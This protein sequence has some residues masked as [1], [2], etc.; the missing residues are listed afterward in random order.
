MNKKQLVLVLLLSVS[1]S[2]GQALEW[3]E[4][5]DNYNLPQSVKVFEAER[6]QPALKI[7]YIDVDLNDEN[8]VVRPYLSS[9][10][11]TV[12]SLADKFGA[13]AAI[14]GGYFGGGISYS[15]VIYPD[16]VKARNVSA[17]TRNG[18]SYPVIRSLFSLSDSF[19]PSVDWI[20]HFS[21]GKDGIYSFE[22][23]LAYTYNDTQPLPAPDQSDGTQMDSLL[24]GIGGGPTLVKN[25]EKHVTYNEEIFWG[26]GVGLDNNDPRTAVGYT[27]DNHIILI[28]ADGRQSSSEGV[29]LNELAEIM[30]DLG[31]VEAMNLDGGGSSQMAV[32]G[33]FINSPSEN[34]AVPGILA[35][36]HR[37]SL[38]SSDSLG[39]DQIID[40]ED[41]QCDTIGNWFETANPGYWGATPSLLS[42]KGSGQDIVTYDLNLSEKKTYEI[43]G[44]WVA[45][46]NRCKDTPYVIVWERSRDTVLVD[47][48]KNNATWNYLGEYNFSPGRDSIIISDAATSGNYVVADAIALKTAETSLSPERSIPDQI[49][50]TMVKNFPNPFNNQTK[51]QFKINKSTRVNLKIYNMAGQLIESIFTN[52]TFHPGIHRLD[53]NSTGLASGIYFFELSTQKSAVH[54]KMLLIK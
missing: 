16:K 26:S 48:T 53:F 21:G 52:R 14:N 33:E 27:A 47:Q 39:Y 7:Y 19:L 17:L 9:S 6:N 20:Y 46:N 24:T 41:E 23:P 38:Y 22:A 2:L 13:Y 37:D 31:C 25:S 29:G 45:A 12:K 42:Q 5:S 50:F 49:K 36:T 54:Q 4:I 44:W 34:R 32:P 3:E 51:I 40:T 10:S 30:I 18:K 8:V 43:Y 11:A 15:A 1:I 35:V 28:T